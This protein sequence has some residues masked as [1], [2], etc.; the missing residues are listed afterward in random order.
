MQLLLEAMAILV[1]ERGFPA[2]TGLAIAREAGRHDSAIN[3]IFGNVDGLKRAYVARKDY[4]KPQ[5]ESLSSGNTEEELKACF[6]ELMQD[7][8]MKFWEDKEMQ[9]II[10]W[11]MTDGGKLMRSVSEQREREAANLLGMTDRFFAGTNT[12]FKT[13]LALVLYGT[14]GMVL[15]AKN[16]GSTVSGID[17]NNERER[18]VLHRTITQV[19]EWAWESSLQ[20]DGKLNRKQAKLTMNYEFD[21][22]DGLS[23]ERKAVLAEGADAGMADARM[24]AEVRRLKKLIKRHLIGMENET[25]IRT[26]MQ[27]NLHTLVNICDRLTVTERAGN[28]DAELVLE[29]LE[30]IRQDMQEYI[31]QNL[32]VPLLVV[33]RRSADFRARWARLAAEWS[34]AGVADEL[35]ELAGLPFRRFQTDRNV[36]W[37]DYRYLQWYSR[38]LEGFVATGE[39][40]DR[41]LI[42]ALLGLGFNSVRF[43]AWMVGRMEAELAAAAGK[44]R[45]V[46]L[47]GYRL[48]I[49]Q[50]LPQSELRYNRFRAPL[51]KQ[52]LD[53]IDAEQDGWHGRREQLD[54][55]VELLTE[56]RERLPEVSKT[57]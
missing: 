56:V 52:L 7:N 15:H 51:D 45:G 32:A 38:E 27:I 49:R 26:Y 55:V 36:R 42:G 53:W 30:E 43:V 33:F 35:L 23:E 25:Q 1:K 17:I 31:P 4:W 40:N 21:V 18:Q 44:E 8:L 6:T 22:L 12:S 29:L 11:Q 9:R 24:V 16:N 57:R 50:H 46:V 2:A 10:A 34:A 13:V 5:L 28:A 20:P 54:V 3:R 37:C 39:L 14:Y 19:L 41:R 48:M 47:K